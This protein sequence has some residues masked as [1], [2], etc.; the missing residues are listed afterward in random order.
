MN[1]VPNVR[2]MLPTAGLAIPASM[3]NPALNLQLAPP[4]EKEDR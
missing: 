1:L 2:I 4:K 3:N